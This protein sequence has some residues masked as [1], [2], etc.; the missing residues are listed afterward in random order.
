MARLQGISIVY[1]AMTTHPDNYSIQF[2]ACRALNSAARFHAKNQESCRKNGVTKAIISA[3]N[4]YNNDQLLVEMAQ[5]AI[6][7]ITC[8]QD[9][10]GNQ[11]NIS[12]TTSG[13]Q[14]KRT[15][16]KTQIIPRHSMH[17]PPLPKG[18]NGVA[19]LSHLSDS[20]NASDVSVERLAA[21]NQ[22]KAA[23]KCTVC[24][25]TAAES[26]LRKLMKCSGCTVAPPYCSSVCQKAHWSAHK[27]ECKA[28]R[29]AA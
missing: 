14:A 7:A 15:E 5:G 17:E 18:M 24:G 13:K 3:A 22:E 20:A 12:E 21:S 2:C 23:Q 9:D 8:T 4:R 6:A 25:K 1:R 16:A 27:L 29:N 10:A 11:A 19:A 26:G 28:N